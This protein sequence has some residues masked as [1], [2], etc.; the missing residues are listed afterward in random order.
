[1]DVAPSAIYRHQHS[2]Q[3]TTL[4][5]AMHCRVPRLHSR[6]AMAVARRVF[7]FDS[8]VGLPKPEDFRD[9]PNMWFEGQL[10]MDR[11]KLE[12]KLRR[13][14]LC[15]GPLKE[16]ISTFIAGNP[17]PVGFASFD[18]DLYSSTRDALE[19]S[20]QTTTISFQG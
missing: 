9:Q 5:I 12:P 6:R 10:P 19:F 11:A 20:N 7:G 13:G 14:K 15:L 2:F 17:A 3:K 8:G 18:V 16:T 4:S 1:M